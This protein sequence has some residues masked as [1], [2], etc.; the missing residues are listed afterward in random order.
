LIAWGS[1]EGRALDLGCGPLGVLDVLSRLVGPS[2][3][4][5]GIDNEPRMIAHAQRTISE[6]DLD[7]VTLMPGDAT[8]TGL[9]ADSF[10]VVHERLVL[11][12][13]HA[14]QEIVDEMVRLAAPAGWVVVEEVDHFSWVCAP[15][16][17]AWDQLYEALD[18]A[19]RAAGSDVFIG[20]RL[21]SLLRTAG[22]SEVGCDVHA[23]LWRRGDPYQTLILQFV[24]VFRERIL[25]DELLREA[26]LD[27][28]IRKLECHLA[29]PGTSVIHPLFFQAW[30]R[31]PA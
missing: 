28:L 16:H 11:I 13:H 4:V 31:K 10:E 22:L 19:W 6:R 5:V 7:N 3:E 17:P 20:R 25:D 8:G 14:P 12:N 23:H 18:H 21:P 1:N 24:D 26:E 2:G 15:A 9:A 27:D 30:G 29:Q